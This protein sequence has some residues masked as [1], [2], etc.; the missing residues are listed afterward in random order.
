[1]FIKC[2]SSILMNFEGITL[3][4]RLGSDMLYRRENA[5]PFTLP[6]SKN[7]YLTDFNILT[8]YQSCRYHRQRRSNLVSDQDLNS[9]FC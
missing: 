2:I 9:E 5:I 3:R 7:E 8:I 6:P 4:D 1:M